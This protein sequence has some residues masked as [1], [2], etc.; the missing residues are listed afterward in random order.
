MNI[1]LLATFALGSLCLLA[2]TAVGQIVT[3]TVTASGQNYG[4]KTKFTFTV[5]PTSNT[6]TIVV[7]NTIAGNGGAEGTITSFG[8]NTPFSDA[9][10]G[11]N[12]SNVSFTQ[13]WNTTL[14]GHTT[15]K[16]NKFEPY[17]ISQNGGYNTDLGVGTGTTPTGG[18][19]ADGIKF[20]EKVT[21]VFTFPDFAPGQIN[22]FFD[23]NPDLIVRWQEVGFGCSNGWSDYGTADLPPA[24]EP[25]TYGLIGAGALLS[26]A[27]VRRQK[28]KIAQR[29]KNAALQTV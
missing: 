25:S 18:T 21:F 1:R 13:T 20:G 2:S 7:D 11:N 17:Q 23:Q 19:S 24:P 6:L 5:N 4:V 14:P 28:Q 12:G 15:W 27:V 16:W 3:K 10:L 8:F 26:L 22:G 9:Q 29:K